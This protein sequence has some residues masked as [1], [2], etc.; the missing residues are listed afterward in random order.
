MIARFQF[1][2]CRASVQAL[3][4]NMAVKFAESSNPAQNGRVVRATGMDMKRD[5]DLIID[6]WPQGVPGEVPGHGVAERLL[7]DNGVERISHVVHPQVS[8]FAAPDVPLFHGT[9]LLVL[10]G[11]G[12][13]RLAMNHNGGHLVQ[14]WLNSIGLHAAVLK[15]RLPNSEIMQ[16]PSIGPLQDVQQAARLVRQRASEHTGADPVIGIYGTSAGGHLAALACTLSD[17]RVYP[18]E[19]DAPAVRLN[20]AILMC[21]VITLDG[22]LAHSGSRRRL[23]GETPSPQQIDRFSAERSVSPRTPPTLLFHA[24][25]DPTV[26]YQNSLL[27]L[28]ALRQAGVPAEVHLFER[29]GHGFKM[30]KEGDSTMTWPTI[31]QAWMRMHGWTS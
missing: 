2:L 6:L 9:T 30:G 13:S 24:I 18:L 15:Y 20:F 14:R 12:Y 3:Q 25:D 5:P 10:P 22:P 8:V 21:P 7:C 4:H 27:Y 31:A 29:G 19:E 17:E 1:L 16:D 23:L 26:P 28:D 11:G